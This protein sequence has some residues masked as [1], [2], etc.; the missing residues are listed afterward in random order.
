MIKIHS[1]HH[2]IKPY[3]HI[4]II[5]WVVGLESREAFCSERLG[6]GEELRR[7]SWEEVNGIERIRL[8]CDNK[9]QIKLLLLYLKQFLM[10]F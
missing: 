9:Q 2:T 1:H 5:I 3:W 8:G 6:G 10:D 7:C 4:S